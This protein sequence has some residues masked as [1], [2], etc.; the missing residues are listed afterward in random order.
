MFAI[1]A[2]T[3]FDGVPETL[4]APII[5]HFDKIDA[6]FEA[7]RAADESPEFPWMRQC[8]KHRDDPE[9][10]KRNFAKDTIEEYAGFVRLTRKAAL[11][12]RPAGCSYGGSDPRQKSITFTIALEA[13][14]HEAAAQGWTIDAG[15][16]YG[17]YNV[18]VSCDEPK[19]DTLPSDP[20]ACYSRFQ[21]PVACK[22][23]NDEYTISGYR[24]VPLTLF[25]RIAQV[26]VNL[27][28]PDRGLSLEIERR[29]L[30]LDT[31]ASYKMLVDATDGIVRYKMKKCKYG[32]GGSR[33]D[34][35]SVESALRTTPHIRIALDEFRST[36]EP[37]GW[38][39]ELSAQGNMLRI[40]ILPPNIA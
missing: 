37:L 12:L 2:S 8:C 27:E 26:L 21:I 5:T 10:V 38:C 36:F 24:D 17:S 3:I 7:S 28:T 33:T 9:R 34:S 22:T 40:K 25:D 31:V 29:D 23:S 30:V 32:I 4:S 11:S 14:K 20:C 16:R 19:H 39:V 1:P 6:Q 18:E 13:F 35:S 15:T